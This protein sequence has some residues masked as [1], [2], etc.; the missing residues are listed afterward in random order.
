M[1]APLDRRAAVVDGLT[2]GA[3]AEGFEAACEI[4]IGFVQA[5]AEIVTNSYGR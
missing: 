1:L 3:Q 4:P 2:S 5:G